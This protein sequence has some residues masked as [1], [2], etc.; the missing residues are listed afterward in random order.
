[1]KAANKGI[2]LSKQLS[3]QPAFIFVIDAARTIHSTDAGIL[4][5][6]AKALLRQEARLTL[7]RLI[8]G[9]EPGSLP[10]FMPE[11]HPPAEI[12][13]VARDWQADLIVMG[14]HGRTGLVHLLTGSVAEHVLQYSSVPVMIVPRAR[15]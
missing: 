3:A 7:D 2:E 5:E 13:R 9:F 6:E 4:P 8:K 12:I 1:M 11:G 14:T 15:S 10:T